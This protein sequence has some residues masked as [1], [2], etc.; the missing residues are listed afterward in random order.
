M[1]VTGGAASYFA[2]FEFMAEPER[3]VFDRTLTLDG[4]RL[5]AEAL[6]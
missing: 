4:L 6:P 3:V 5:A 2:G 1:Y